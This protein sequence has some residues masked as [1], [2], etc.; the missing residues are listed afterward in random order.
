MA[1]TGRISAPSFFSHLARGPNAHGLDVAVAGYDLCPQVRVGDIVEEL[2]AAC[3]ELARFER[4]LVV[5]GHSAGGHLTA[6]MTA[7]SWPAV[8]EKLPRDFVTAGY[9]I[10][11]I[12]A[13]KPL[14]QT[15]INTALG[16]DDAEAEL[17]SPLTWQAPAGL[18]FDAVV[19]GDESPEY[20][21]QSRTIAERWGS[22]GVDTRYEAVPGAKPLH[23]HRAARRPRLGDDAPHRRARRRLRLSTVGAAMA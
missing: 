6:C 15:S 16:M 7:T 13:L 4:R 18:R 22:A 1:A 17:Q 21:R 10:S 20:L 14:V 11:G 12:F 3:R 9:A 23:G 19:G 5:A 8:D 2:R